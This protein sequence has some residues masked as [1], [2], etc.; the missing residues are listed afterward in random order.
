M[1][2]APETAQNNAKRGLEL[3]QK[4]GR[5][6]TMVG[7]ARARDLSNGADLS[8]STIRRMAS[9][10]RH[11]QNY[12]P[13]K[14]E[15]DGGPTAG[16]IAWLLWGGTAGVDWA[17]RISNENKSEMQI[18]RKTFDCQFEIKQEDNEYFYLK[19]Y[20]AS[21]NN[22][23]A[24][25]DVIEPKAFE[26]SIKT[27]KPKLLYGHDT[28]SPTIGIIDSIQEDNNGLLFE[29]RMPKEDDFVRG[30]LMPQI[31]IGAMNSFSIGYKVKQAEN[32]KQGNRMLKE[33]DLY[34]ISLVTFPANDKATLQSFKAVD[35]EL[36]L[37]LADR[38]KEWDSNKAV[39]N[40]RQYTDSN[41][42]PSL[43]YA[44]YFLYYDAENEDNFTAYKLPFVDIIDNEPTIIPRAIFAIAGALQGARGGLDVPTADRQEIINKIN[45]LY[46][47]MA[48]EFE[49]ETLISPLK[50][51]LIESID[52][53]RALEKAIASKFSNQDAKTIVAKAKD[54]FQRDV[55]VKDQRDAEIMCE[56]SL[57]TALL[58]IKN[59]Q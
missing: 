13:D 21:F 10:N 16:T 52:S 11:R 49:D 57:Q 7:V 26:K 19:A 14:K 9:F 34:E 53:I 41:D 43:D 55:E 33:I 17:I 32:N 8:L 44:N 36:N 18:Q 37:P 58:Q 31:K 29:A 47:R 45:A 38:E 20:G 23:D 5:G 27:R 3:R 42:A 56:L 4:W 2:V 50:K 59:I 35:P 51:D 25:N 6:G 48:K 15:N 24:V 46:V 12:Q 1:P 30:R 54:I 39:A 28:K 40:I 22:I